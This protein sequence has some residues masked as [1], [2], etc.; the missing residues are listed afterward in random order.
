MRPLLLE[1]TLPLP[2]LAFRAFRDGIRG[3]EA[4]A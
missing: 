1:P 4:G 2:T 3:V